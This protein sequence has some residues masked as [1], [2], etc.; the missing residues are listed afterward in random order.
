MKARHVFALLVLSL[1]L[2]PLSAYAAPVII[3][4]EGFS[5]TIYNSPITRLGY[6]IG[7]PPA[8]E[9]HFH[10]ADSTLY[11]LVSNG[12]GVLVNDRDTEIFLV[13]TGNSM[14]TF[15][16]FSV[17]VATSLN[18]YPAVG[19]DIRGYL[20]NVLVGTVSLANL[21]GV[22]T[23]LSGASLGT[24]DRLVFDGIGDQGGFE[25]DNITLNAGVPDAGSS[26]LLLGIAIAGLKA[27]KQRLM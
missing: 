23:T 12:T 22:F 6:D 8:Q 14:A 20:N 1:L 11:G 3:T 19:I 7:N 9:Q 15:T 18:N 5:N 2:S 4:F 17:D 13:A 21:G 27:W 24:V 16:L 25:L 10:E 26:L